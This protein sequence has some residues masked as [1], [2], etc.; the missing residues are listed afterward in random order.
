[1]SK[2]Y[3]KYVLL[4]VQNSNNIYV[5]ESGIFYL[6]ID[7]D[8]KLMSNILGLKLTNLNSFIVKCGFPVRSADKYFNLLKS[9]N[10]NVEIVPADNN[11]S[12]TNVSNYLAT[13]QYRNIIQDFLRVDVDSLSISQAFDLLADLQNKFNSVEMENKENEEKE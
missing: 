4:K 5:F 1:M 9:L 6:F 2:L 3:K 13:K 11:F 12:P 10:Y 8:A 7:E